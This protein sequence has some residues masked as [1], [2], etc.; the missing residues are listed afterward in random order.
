MDLYTADDGST[1]EVG[2]L[3][4]VASLRQV[5]SRAG[6]AQLSCTALVATQVWLHKLLPPL[7]ATL[8]EHG[9]R[10]A[11]CQGCGHLDCLRLAQTL[12]A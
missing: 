4:N 2:V 9:L 7:L 5:C 11:G 8:V 1:L 6:L 3:E 12:S 10:L